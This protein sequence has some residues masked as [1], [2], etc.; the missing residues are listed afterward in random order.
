MNINAIKKK[1]SSFEKKDTKQSYEDRPKIP[2]F[3]PTIGKQ[4]IRVVP[5]KHNKDYPFT[6]MKMYYNIGKFKLI[7]SPLNW[8]DKDP[9]AEFAKKL[10]ETNDSDKWALAKKLD[11]KVRIFLPVV[12]RGEEEQG[13]KYWEFG[14]QVYQD[15]LNLAADEEV[16]D[17]TDI[18]EGRDIKITTVGPDVTGTSYNKTTISPS[19]K[20]TPLSKDSDLVERLLDEQPHPLDFYTN[21]PFDTIKDALQNWFEEDEEEDDDFVD[22]EPNLED[23]NPKST[24]SLSTQGE[25]KKSNVEK[26]EDM[27]EDE[28]E[29]DL[30]F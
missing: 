7:C 14:K 13:V 8:G 4:T 12:V 22:A 10:R 20:Q 5:F 30:P 9:I 28:D 27:F 23:K 26:F 15:F 29:D 1:L 6:E 2:K 19:M 17:F 16:G 25:A 24:Y 18:L 3:K 21:L 11:F